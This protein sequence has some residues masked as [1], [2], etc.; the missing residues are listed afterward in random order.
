MTS[1]ENPKRLPTDLPELWHGAYCEYNS[2]GVLVMGEMGKPQFFTDPDE[3]WLF[4]M[5]QAKRGGA[6]RVEARLP[7]G[8]QREQRESIAELVE[9]YKANGGEITKCD[10]DQKLPKAKVDLSN[11]E[12]ELPL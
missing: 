2:G 4:L 3:L 5:E 8:T 7:R 11:L 10:A 6:R 1:N 12:L 9:H